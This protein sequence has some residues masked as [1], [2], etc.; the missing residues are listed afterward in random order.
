MVNTNQ[1]INFNSKLNNV[2]NII[3]NPKLA[4]YPIETL[5]L[6]LY[7]FELRAIAIRSYIIGAQGQGLYTMFVKPSIVY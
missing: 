4:Y 7:T 3:P 2:P 5:T 1:S 6:I